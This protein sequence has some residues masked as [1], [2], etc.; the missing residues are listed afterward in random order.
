[1]KIW[2][3]DG[4]DLIVVPSEKVKTELSRYAKAGQNKT[5]ITVLPYPLGK[6]LGLRLTGEEYAQ[7]LHQYS[8]DS[9]A[10]INVVLPV[11]GAAVGLGYYDRLIRQLAQSS[12]RFRM[13]LVIS[14]TVHTKAFISTMKAKRHMTVV[15]GGSDKEV[16]DNY[17]KVYGQG[18]IALEI[19]KPSEQS[20]KALLAPDQRGG[21]ILLLT[22]AI[23]KQEEDNLQFLSDHKLIPRRALRFTNDPAK[24]V[25]FINRCIRDGIF[26]KMARRDIESKD[27]EL[28]SNGVAQFWQ[29]VDGLV[30]KKL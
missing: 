17:E 18:V 28:A 19:V 11:S 13:H 25:A 26:S 10:K 27:P 2:Y 29:K 4:A 14:T 16:V 6:T 3:V 21:S 8:E 23:G 7:R 12:G 20:F 15:T 22:Q 24:D 9:D 5:E 1:M 30:R